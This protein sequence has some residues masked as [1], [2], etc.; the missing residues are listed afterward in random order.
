VDGDYSEE[1]LIEQLLRCLQVV[2]A[3]QVSHEY[4]ELSASLEEELT[5]KEEEKQDNKRR[6]VSMMTESLDDASG[7]AKLEG[8]VCMPLSAADPDRVPVS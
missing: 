6:K 8:M 3:L 7:A 1:D 4:F 5:K 2:D